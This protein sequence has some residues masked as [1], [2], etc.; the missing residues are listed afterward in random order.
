MNYFKKQISP[1]QLKFIWWAVAVVLFLVPMLNAVKPIGFYFEDSLAAHKNWFP[2]FYYFTWLSFKL[3]FPVACGVILYGIIRFQFKTESRIVVPAIIIQGILLFFMLQTI[4]FTR[5]SLYVYLLFLVG[6]S[7]FVL[8][9]YK[10]V[11]AKYISAFTGSKILTGSFLFII[12]ITLCLLLPR[13]Y[14]FAKYTMFNKFPEHTSVFL[15]R[16]NQGQLIPLKEYSGIDGNHLFE[17]YVA[18]NEQ[19]GFVY[20]SNEETEEEQ[21]LICKELLH[22]ILADLKKPMPFDSVSINRIDYFLEQNKIASHEKQLY[23]CAVE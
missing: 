14:P 6:A 8:N 22:S 15:L 2:S 10:S 3:F 19:H 17:L 21:Q 1:Q 5:V 11:M 16:N 7:V 12:Y 18:T 9:K 13:A 4:G 23:K 20:L